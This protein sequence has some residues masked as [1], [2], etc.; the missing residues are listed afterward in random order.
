MRNALTYSAALS[1]GLIAA[2]VQ[3]SAQPYMEDV[4]TRAV[5]V[6]TSAPDISKHKFPRIMM[7]ET[8]NMDGTLEQFSKY[9][10]ITTSGGSILKVANLQKIYPDLMYFRQLMAAEYLGYTDSYYCSQGHGPGFVNT[11]PAT[12]N[13]N[14][15]SGHWLY[16]A[17]S[18]L[19]QA[20]TATST[21]L[22]VLDA[23]RYTVGSYVVIYDAPAGSFK[24]AEHAK[25]TANN[26][27]TNTLTVSR[28]YKSTALPHPV[29]AIVAQHVTGQGGD[30]RNWSFNLSTACPRD[31][32]GYNFSTAMINW[33][34][35]NYTKRMNGEDTTA[36]VSGFLF[37][38]DFNYLFKNAKKA[39]VDNDLVQEDGV[40]PTGVNMWGNGMTGLYAALRARFPDKY[41]EAGHQFARG[42]SAI[43]GA[44]MEGFPVSSGDFDPNPKY[45]A[46]NS[47][48]SD[49]GFY[50]HYVQNGFAHNSVLNKTPTK[51]Y[52]RGT[53]ASSNAP[54]RISL[55]M[56]LLEDGYFGTQNSTQHP[57]PWF[58]EQAVD[59]HAGSATYGQAIQSNPLDESK[60]RAN[61]G[62]LGNPIGPRVRIY[63]A[64]SFDPSQSLLAPATFDSTLTGWSG[65]NVTV[66]QVTTGAMDGT[67]A[68]RASNHIKYDPSV[69]GSRV[70]GPS[71][72]LVKDAWYTLVFS[73]KAADT[74]AIDANVG[75]Y[76]E[77][78]LVSRTWRR[79]VVAFKAKATGLQAI[80]FNVGRENVETWFDSVYLFQGN[81]NVFRRDFEHGI[82]VVNATPATKIVNL[83]GTFQKI[84]GFQD[85]VINNGQ[86]ISSVTL[87]PFDGV[88]LVR[89]AGISS[90]TTVVASPVAP[91]A[92]SLAAGSECGKPTYD[93][94]TQTGV[95][96]WK[97]CLADTWSV[98]MT[99]GGVAAGVNYKGSV[100][101]SLGFLMMNPVQFASNDS[102]S[103]ASTTQA[104][105]NI[106]V[107]NNAENGLDFVYPAGSAACFRVAVPTDMRVFLGAGGLEISRNFN[108]TTLGGC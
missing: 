102:I 34:A 60:I 74:R 59:V 32:K 7:A 54:L 93:K 24:N 57:D 82:V 46:I 21:T 47:R 68:L 16:Q 80:S 28:A 52:P 87:A 108:L 78:F 61:L 1:L 85:P 13:C 44:Q 56:A 71:V 49:Y 45:E 58:D 66:S 77:S 90:T 12:E 65:T 35:G 15:F 4:D 107:Y 22:A 41:I 67:G 53:T 37:D 30:A 62:W 8:Q 106:S 88:L 101:T 95:F 100:T 9:N 79:Y 81:P 86:K 29:G 55:G 89:P 40:S 64:A 17:G 43:N 33:T 27:T 25:I 91:S 96:I 84:K 38:S 26:T 97:D 3:V 42:F 5:P 105:Y 69:F 98:R 14:I 6:N 94:A 83:G 92:P 75:A 48:L 51:S 73:A 39:D 76:A 11:G 99:G 10:I 72:N 23:K 18:P 19:A 2:S 50:A 36:K 20:I 70:K 31:S 104:D 103:Y 63:D